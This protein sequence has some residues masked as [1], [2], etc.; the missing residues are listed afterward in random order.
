MQGSRWS[1]FARSLR[2]FLYRKRNPLAESPVAD[3]TFAFGHLERPSR[4][5]VFIGG[6]GRSG[7]TVLARLLGQHPRIFV[8]RWET[9]LIAAPG[10]LIDLLRNLHDVGARKRFSQQMR[11]PWFQRVLYA[12]QPEEYKA[13]LCADLSWEEI[14]PVL[15]IFENLVKLGGD[16][17]HPFRLGAEFLDVLSRPAVRRAKAHRWGEKTPRNIFYIAQLRQLFPNLRFVHILRDGRDVVASMLENGFWPIAPSPEYPGT[18]RFRGKM[19]FEKAV[20]YWVEMLKIARHSAAQVPP[21]NYLEIRLEDLAKDPAASLKRLMDFLDEPL[22]EEL[23]QFDLSRA[24]AGRWRR[25][26]S[27][28]QIRYFHRHAGEV[29]ER[30]GYAV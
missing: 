27:A 24:R 20:D 14:E 7:T 15:A 23:L 13:G 10:G 16:Q 25:D 21:E 19:S 28:A 1:D 4:G 11:G 9:Q 6:T 26:L 30:E 2:H 3:C 17:I 22:T 8:Y 18:L 5:P 12:G 29:L